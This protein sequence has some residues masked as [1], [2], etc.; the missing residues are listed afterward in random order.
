MDSERVVEEVCAAYSRDR[1]RMMDIVR[2]VQSRLDHVPDE[3][4]SGIAR[5]VGCPRED[6]EG[7]VT[8][9]AFYSQEPR[10]RI[11]IR[12]CDDV[13][14]RLAGYADIRAAFEDE[15]G[16]ALG[17]T[18]PD[19][20]ITLER[21]GCIG[22]CDQAPAAMVND[23]IVTRLSSDSARQI[24]HE[25]RAHMD[26]TKLVRRFGD[27]NNALPLIKAMV[28]NNIRFPGPLLDTPDNRGEAITRALGMSPAEVIRAVKTARLRGRGG[29][30]FPTGM[31]WE[32][33]R[34]APGERRLLFC[35]ADEG[36][37]GTFKDRVLLTERPDRVIAGMTIAGYAIGAR[38]GIMYLRGEYAYL[39]PF[40][41]DVLA[42]RRDDGLLGR[43]ICGRKGFDFDVRIQL[44]AGAY[45]CGE[46]TS[47][48]S[49]CEGLRGDPKNRPPFPAQ[50]GYLGCPSSVNNV[51]TL[52]CVTQILTWGAAAF[53]ER[54]TTQSAG[55]KLLSISG[56]CAQ[57]GVYELPFGTS[58]RDVL[59]LCDCTDASAVLVGGPSGQFVGPDM[60]D[61]AICYDDLST[62]GAIC[63]FG[64]DRDLLEI[65]ST[66]MEFFIDESCGYCT[67][68]RV[69]NVLIKRTLDTI[70]AGRG[71]RSDLDEL[72]A[73]CK[74]VKATSR[75]GLGQTSPNPVL[76]ALER[77]R[78]AFEARISASPPHGR[79]RSF[80]LSG[81]VREA[82]GLAGRS[83]VHV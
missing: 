33:T 80:D 82:E 30:G 11:V 58:L 28:E 36:E 14:D 38:E 59:V 78:P 57:P 1:T 3:A 12:L 79:R 27:G 60:F 24:V 34:G 22:M 46:E 7:V 6:V 8:F 74:T 26:P 62:G 51:E 21:T 9:Y 43:D 2:D 39:Q 73:L 67:P 52:A 13:L 5:C 64:P 54:G 72:T 56:D 50:R 66:Y 55:T 10:G 63:V 19:G 65:I 47:L 18:T 70:M 81:S 69:G 53:R 45:I 83:S 17:E 76:T 37:P 41:D 48:I 75:C 29:A 49:S 25:L 35:N 15:L 31:K 40:L 4:I 71:E 61:R 44:G 23:V 77:F 16:I 32:F 42:Q 20:N 68:C